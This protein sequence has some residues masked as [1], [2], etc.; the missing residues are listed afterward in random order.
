MFLGVRR[1]VAVSWV[2]RLEA[3]VR[4]SKKIEK[5]SYFILLLS[6]EVPE[7]CDSVFAVPNKLLLGLLAIIFFTVHV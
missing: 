4:I 2:Y 5:N 1:S 7:V 6:Q 3:I